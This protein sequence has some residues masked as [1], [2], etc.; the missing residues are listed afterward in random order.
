MNMTFLKL[1]KV[2]QSVSLYVKQT[3]KTNYTVLKGFQIF[4]EL[5]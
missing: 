5:I 2:E 3:N 4:I 1:Y